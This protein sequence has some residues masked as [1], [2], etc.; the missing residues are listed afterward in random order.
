MH[1]N[2]IFDSRFYRSFIIEDTDLYIPIENDDWII[3]FLR[4]CKF[5]PDSARKLVRVLS[6]LFFLRRLRWQINKIAVLSVQ[7]LIHI[8]YEFFIFLVLNCV[9]KSF[10]NS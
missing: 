8:V 3:R 4:P 6:C 10:L 1:K 7:R 9:I 5:Y 2:V